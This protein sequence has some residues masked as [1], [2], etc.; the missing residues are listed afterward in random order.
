MAN[1]VTYTQVRTQCGVGSDITS[2]ADI[3]ALITEIEKKTLSH[4]KVY[5][6]PTKQLEIRDGN[7][8]NTLRL[9]KPYVWKVLKLETQNTNIDLDNVTI[10]PI[11]NIIT[12]DNTQN[13][14]YFF[15][16]QNSIKIKYLSA[17][18]EKTTTITE[19]DADI[20]VGTSVAISVDSETGFAVDDWVLIEGLDGKREAAKITATDTGEI[21][22]D[23]LVQDHE[24]DSVIT[25]LQTHELLTQ[26]VLYESAVA[27]GIN[28]IGGSY[29]FA[30]NVV[31]EGMSASYGVPHPHFSKMTDEN[32]K[33][34]DIIKNQI[35]AKLN[36][37]S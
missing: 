14:Y 18:M 23:E 22:V 34:R 2:D 26:F 16:Y 24:A 15:P 1:L 6:T 35:Y 29:S 36:S 27:V 5:K 9:N 3:T 12:I 30:T 8:K 37:I 13:P 10:D 11:S 32:I 20:E 7:G 21:T 33:Q 28:A 25:K 4:L 31:N 17:F 19:S